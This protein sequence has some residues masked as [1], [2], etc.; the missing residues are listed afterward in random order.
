MRR[1]ILTGVIVGAIVLGIAPGIARAELLHTLRSGPWS[2]GAYSLDGTQKFNSCIVAV[3]YKSGINVG[4]IVNRNYQW[5]LGFSS[6]QW[7][8]QIGQD[9]PVSMT[10]DSSAPWSGKARVINNHSVTVAMNDNASLIS[11][12]RQSLR[13]SVYAGGQ[14]YPFDL[15]GTSRAIVD[16]VACVKAELAAERGEPPPMPAPQHREASTP[17]PLPTQPAAVRPNVDADLELAATRIA[18]NLL[19]QAKLPNAHILDREETPAGL[20]GRGVAWASDIGGGAVEILSAGAAQGPQQIA[21]QLIDADAA[22]CKGDF[23]SGRASELVD[24]TLVTRTFT[25][26]KEAA[27]TQSVR[28]FILHKEGAGY[29][30]YAL[31][32]SDAPN[33]DNTRPAALQDT[34]FQAAAIKAAFP[35]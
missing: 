20:R 22:S 31:T 19:L 6:Q 11:S 3:D 18:S 9:I 7:N 29:I 4:I 15:N 8:L 28:Y 35:Q 32:G 30:V 10:F 1:S 27:G 5:Y 13:M 14:V 23:V 2:G 24:N 16:L 21:S 17:P 25:G 12:F 26:C 33:A 34:A